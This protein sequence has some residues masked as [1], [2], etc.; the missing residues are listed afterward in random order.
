M[1]SLN[2]GRV[3]GWRRGAEYKRDFR[4]IRRLR[5]EVTESREKG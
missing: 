2:Q 5:E 3:D 4:K 1:R